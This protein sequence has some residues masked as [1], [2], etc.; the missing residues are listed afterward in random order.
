MKNC[1]RRRG[2]YGDSHGVAVGQ[3]P[4]VRLSK[5]LL[6]RMGVRGGD[7]LTADVRPDGSLVLRPS[8]R[9]IRAADLYDLLEGDTSGYG[10]VELETGAP[11]GSELI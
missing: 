11:V 8:K 3:Q 2:N 1:L 4:A 5:S 6:E 10:A 7:E 9:P